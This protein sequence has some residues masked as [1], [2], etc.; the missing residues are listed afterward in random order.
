MLFTVLPLLQMALLLAI[1]SKFASVDLAVPGQPDSTSPFAVGGSLS[2]GDSTS[3]IAQAVLGLVFLVI[4]IFAWRGRPSWIRFA[5]L[6]AVIVLTLVTM[7]LSAAPLL[8]RADFSQG[9]DSG[10]GLVRT[11]LSGRLLMSIL[12]A[13]YVVWYMNRGPAR[14]FYRGYY[15]SAANGDG[16][17]SRVTVRNE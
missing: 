13:F 2:G 4:T 5:M 14:A 10:A 3:L 9:I 16:A 6:G 8:T 15:L 1:R 12:V 11:L 7:V 17:D